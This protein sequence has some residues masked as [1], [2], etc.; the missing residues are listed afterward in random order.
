MATPAATAIN[1]EESSVNN[2]FLSMLVTV[3][4]LMLST[5]STAQESTEALTFKTDEER[6]SYSKGIQLGNDFQ[7]THIQCDPDM[8]L[9]G[10]Q[11]A[12]AGKESALDANELRKWCGQ[13]QEALQLEIQRKHQEQNAQNE[14]AGK[15]F[16]AQNAQKD[17]IVVLPSGLQ[18]KIIKAGTGRH[19]QAGEHVRAHYLGT[20]I[21]GEQFDSSHEHGSPSEFHLSRVIQGWQEGV[22]L[23]KEKG[24]WQFFIP[25]ALA[26]GKRGAGSLIKPGATL[27]FEIELLEIIQE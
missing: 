24:H 5:V 7:D 22:P 2:K 14:A 26:Y 3:V 27:I 17:G 19:P 25:A 10:I 6:L 1:D 8:L 13:F 16:L 20:L 11:D 21:T 9:R 12:L 23:M 4:C 15:A 18:Y